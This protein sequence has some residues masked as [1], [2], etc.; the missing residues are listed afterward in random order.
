MYSSYHSI[1]YERTVKKTLLEHVDSFDWGPSCGAAFRKVKLQ[2][3]S[4]RFVTICP[5]SRPPSVLLEAKAKDCAE[6]RLVL[7][8][9]QAQG[10]RTQPQEDRPPCVQLHRRGRHRGGRGQ[11]PGQGG[12]QRGG[13]GGRR[14]LPGRVGNK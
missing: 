6:R 3:N 4:A 9:L 11:R 12:G 14:G 2:K 8:R 13:R 7:Q 1:M 5:F 10:A